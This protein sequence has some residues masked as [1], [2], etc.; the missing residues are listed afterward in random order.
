MSTTD[1]PMWSD[2]VDAEAHA[3]ALADIAS[4]VYDYDPARY[5]WKGYFFLERYKHHMETMGPRFRE[6]DGKEAS[7]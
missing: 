7:Q 2:D 4:K 3:T 5:D 6:L 1:E